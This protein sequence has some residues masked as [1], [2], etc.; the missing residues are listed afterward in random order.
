[1]VTT[2]QA[3]HDNRALHP[4]K[5]V[6]GVPVVASLVGHSRKKNAQCSCAQTQVDHMG[7][8]PCMTKGADHT[9]SNTPEPGMGGTSRKKDPPP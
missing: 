6:A 3:G 9:H 8:Q 2:S 1:M 5:P 7:C 4:S